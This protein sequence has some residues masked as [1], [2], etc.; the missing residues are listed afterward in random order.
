L[1]FCRISAARSPSP[2]RAIVS[3][4]IGTGS[5]AKIMHDSAS[6]TLDLVMAECGPPTSRPG[7]TPRRTSRF[8]NEAALRQMMSLEV[9]LPGVEKGSPRRDF[10]GLETRHRA[11]LIEMRD[12]LPA[13]TGRGS[14][15]VL[16]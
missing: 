3:G 9:R 13:G 5:I 12:P 1:T 16:S 14:S 15:Y 11:R 4:G 6:F 8:F 10:S 7:S 2:A